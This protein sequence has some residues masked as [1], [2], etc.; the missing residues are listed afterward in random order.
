MSS[1][2]YLV[3]ALSAAS[4]GVLPAQT[5]RTRAPVVVRV[6]DL[7]WLGPVVADAQARAAA[8]LAQAGPALAGVGPA[9]AQA[10]IGL[11]RAEAAL[12]A[13]SARMGS[14]GSFAFAWDEITESPP[15]PWA[16]QDP[17]D[18]IYRNARQ[19]LNRGRY[20]T[21]ADLFASIYSKHPRS[22]Y[23]GDAYYWQAYALSR[24]D[25]SESLRQAL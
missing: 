2:R 25:N 21:A 14:F 13:T 19:E 22:T 1:V 4:V 6:P 12:A 23:A 18:Q 20:A 16:Q 15:A 17:A 11:L 24:R 8:S 10:R 3:L 9:M 7:S 5:A